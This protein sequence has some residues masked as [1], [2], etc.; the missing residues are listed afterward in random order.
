MGLEPMTSPLPRECSTTE[1]HQPSYN[2]STLPR[3]HAGQHNPEREKSQ[4]HPTQRLEF[5]RLHCSPNQ[6]CQNSQ[7]DQR[8]NQP[9][10]ARGSHIHLNP[11]N[12]L[13]N[14]QP[15]NVQPYNFKKWCTG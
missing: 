5:P 12:T 1:L 6:Y 4:Q 10:V 13:L 8:N 15:Y 14:L 2:T 9:P 11:R 3:S 7:H